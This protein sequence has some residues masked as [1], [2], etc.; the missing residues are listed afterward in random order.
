[1]D[2]F[3]IAMSRYK[4]RKYDQTIELCEQMLNNNP[5]DEAAWLLKCNSMIRKQYLDDLEVDEEGL[6][7]MLMD[8]NQISSIQRPG[9]S[10]QRINT[11][12]GN[13]NPIQRPTSKSGRPITG[14]SRPGNNRPTTSQQGRLDTSMRGNAR[15]GTS[16]PITSGGRHMRLGTASL[17]GNIQGFLQTDKLNMRNIAKK[18]SIAKAICNYLLYI[19]NN[20]KKALELAAEATQLSD[21]QDWWWKE[22]LGRCYYQLGMFREAESQFNSSIRNEN[23]I[24]TQLELSRTYVRLNVPQKAIEIF[25]KALENHPHE[26]AFI[27]GIARIYDIMNQSQKAVDYYKQVLEFESSNMES[28]A[29]IAAY[30]FYIDQPEVSMKFY[31]RLLQL[32]VNTSEIWN[33][34]ALCLFYDG[35]YDLFY[36]CFERALMLAQDE[37]SKAEIWYNISHIYINL[38]D[39]GMAYKCLKVVLSYDPTHAEAYNNLGI[40]E[41][42]KNG[43]IERGKYE[44][45]Q[46]RKEGEFLIEPHYNSALWAYN[47]SEFQQAYDF[48]KKAL[49]IYPDHADSKKLLKNIENKL[50]VI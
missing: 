22:R 8:E 29:S 15:L 36:P 11:G 28:V 35:Q 34:L 43:S 16:R 48:V 13:L 38:G 10:L 2:D 9:T 26:I 24:K 44:L 21:Y 39:L 4:R 49:E 30:H 45:A 37:I 47:S 1:M 40:L 19:E 20:P 46:S 33:N 7:D 17:A 27:I 41:I 25:Q 42:R 31:Q 32:G 5:R 18:K 50:K 14:F 3:I 12:A 6:G 23:I